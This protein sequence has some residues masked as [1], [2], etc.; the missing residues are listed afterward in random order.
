[1]D[2]EQCLLPGRTSINNHSFQFHCHPQVSCYLVCCHNVDMLLFPFDVILLKNHLGIHSKEFLERYIELCEGSHP[3]FPGIKLRMNADEQHSCPFLAENGCHVYR[4][5]PSACRTYPLE[6]G[7]EKPS[8][9]KKL[10]V[11]YFMTHHPYCKGH[12]ESRTYSIEQWE[13]DQ[14]LHECNDYNDR[15]AELDAFFATN[16]WA[17]EGKAGPFQQLAFLVCYNIDAFR[18]YLEHHR[19]LNQF[20]ISKE[21]RRRILRD[22]GALMLFGFDWL[23]TV[24]GGRQKLTKK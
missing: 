21:E 5:R 22:D 17:G 9:G 6:R 10:Q 15:W 18:E 13:R 2:L 7:V 14:M 24:L 3:Y 19:L 16:P 11:H 8:P 4:N 20:R 23:E 1:M 12:F